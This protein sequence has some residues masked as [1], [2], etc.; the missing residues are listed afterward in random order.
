MAEPHTTVASSALVGASLAGLGALVG[1]FAAEWLLIV[2][3][4]FL[5]GCLAATAAETV[6]ARAAAIVVLRGTVASILFT[7]VAVLLT[8]SWLGASIDILLLP[9][10][11]LIGWQFD[12]LKDLALSAIGRR[13]GGAS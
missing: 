7:T 2:I 10:A 9:T 1:P 5:G 12:R 8:A 11:G 6:G 3:G 4:G 13:T